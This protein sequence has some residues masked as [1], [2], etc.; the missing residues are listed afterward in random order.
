MISRDEVIEKLKSV[1]DPEIRLDVWTLGLIYKIEIEN[2]I[3]KI[4]MTFTT[5]FCPYGEMLL[6]QI[7]DSLSAIKG[8]KDVE[9]EITFEPMWQ[10]SE[11]VKMM[12]G[13]N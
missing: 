13:V 8:I 1:V 12:L 10:P 7:R 3:V 2:D 5:P 6:D 9:I 4:L 11:E